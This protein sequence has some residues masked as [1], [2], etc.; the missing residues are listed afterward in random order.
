MDTDRP[1]A[2]PTSVAPELP[3]AATGAA[4]AATPPMT[5]QTTDPPAS[6]DDVNCKD[7]R[8]GPDYRCIRNCGPPVARAGDPDPGWGWSLGRPHGCPKCLPGEARIATPEGE[9]AVSELRA[10]MPVW[11][12]SSLGERVVARVARASSVEVPRDHRVVRVTLSDGRVVVASPGHPTADGRELGTLGAG[13]RL[14]GVVVTSVESV[15]FGAARTYDILPT[16][17][18]GVYWADGVLVGSTLKESR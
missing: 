15:P 17:E 13:Q 3:V 16:G 7:P 14:D 1:A 12:M 9:V 18:T 10:G 5:P 8:P 2:A 11:T 6:A 4:S